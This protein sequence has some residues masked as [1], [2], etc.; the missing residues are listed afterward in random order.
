MSTITSQI[1]LTHEVDPG[2]LKTTETHLRELKEGVL[3][4]EVEVSSPYSI[5]STPRTTDFEEPFEDCTQDCR[6][7]SGIE[8]A[9]TQSALLVTAD[10]SYKIVA[11]FPVPQTLA[12][13]EVMIRNHATGLNHI[14]WKSVDYNFC[15]PELPWITGREMAGVVERVGA[16]VTKYQPGDKVWTSTYYKDRRAGCFQDLVVVPQ[17]TVFP[18]PSSLN[19]NTAACLGVAALTAAMSLWRWLGVPMHP[20]RSTSS[21]PQKPEV[22]LVWGGSTVTGQ[23]AIQVAAQAGL[24]VIAVCSESTASLVASLGAAHVVTYNNKTDLHIIGEILCLADG[25]LTKA[26]DLVGAKTAKLVLQLIAACGEKEVEFA[27]LAFMSSKDPIPSNARVHTVEMKQFVLDST[28]EVYGARLNE[29]VQ[30]GTL[31]L[32]SVKVLEGGLAAVEEGLRINISAMD[33]KP[34]DHR[35]PSTCRLT[36]NHTREDAIAI[37][38]PGAATYRDPFGVPSKTPTVLME[39]AL[40]VLGSYC[41]LDAPGAVPFWRSLARSPRESSEVSSSSNS[42][43]L[44]RTSFEEHAMALDVVSQSANRPYA[45]IWTSHLGHVAEQDEEPGRGKR[46]RVTLACQRCKTRKQKCDGSNPCEKCKANNQECCY[47]IPQKP[48]PFGK[49][50][51]IKALERRVAELET[52]LS[53]QGMTELSSDHWAATAESTT[54]AS[55]ARSNPTPEPEPDEPDEAVLDWRDGV[56]SVV[57]VVR[58]LSLDVN[59]SGY[60][61]AS[62]HVA[63]GRVFAF[64]AK[65]KHREAV[66]TGQPRRQSLAASTAPRHPVNDVHQPIDF[67]DVPAGIADRLFNGYLKHIATRWPVVHSVWVRELH[68]RRHSLTDVFELTML[69][70]LYA[71]AG[72]FIETTGETGEFHVK[73]HYA[74]AAQ[75]LDT[76]HQFNDI[77]TVQVLMLMAVYCLRDSIGPG[78]WTCSR[79]ALLIAIDH[80]LHRQTKALSRLSMESELRKRLFWSCY[81]FDRQIS[82]PMGRPFGISDRDIDVELPLDIDE[83]TTQ[84]QLANLDSILG[85]Q[86]KATSMTSFILIARLRR[87]ESDIQQTVYRVDQSIVIDDAIIDGFLHRLEVWKSTIPQDCRRMRDVGDVPFDGYDYYMVFYHKCLRLLLYPQISKTNVAPRFLKECAKAC[88]GICG[89]Y[90][91]LHQTLAVGYSFMALQTVFMAG[92][93]LV[94]CIWISPAEIFDMITSNGIHD[95]SILLFVIAERVLPAKKYRNAFEVIRQRVIDHISQE[96]AAPR[97]AMAG[98]TEELA[99]S[100]QSFQVNMP[101]EVDNGSFEEFSQII[102]DMTGEEFAGALG[103]AGEEHMGDATVDFGA[104]AMYRMPE[105]FGTGMDYGTNG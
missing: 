45:P 50:Q 71:T 13:H 73:R 55:D 21:Q 97:E 63:L 19:F 74:S 105:G 67:A 85:S 30:D 6:R 12:P 15:L 32:P 37:A 25:R 40:S 87:I 27:P 16:G 101:F 31:R 104:G 54:S 39:Q 98:L 64:L 56:D 93:T 42:V 8:L 76:I 58:S 86:T 51:Y 95:C 7:D 35:L 59:G 46:S 99:P 44:G 65:T 9:Q 34:F 29:M 77:R 79:T 10:R 103:R 89:A 41:T 22:M 102:T 96:P 43:P 24:D 94:Y 18:I 57:S 5:A 88:A 69:H 49:N 48:M 62:S 72:R 26:V 91:R 81:A 38:P 84:E 70:L 3:L 78:A 92:L 33:K 90:K 36:L 52:F 61:G 17:H 68:A 60:M 66:E 83:D 1:T 14:D 2:T 23:F 53:T 82:I 75:S 47:V 100:A 28:S 20:P 80:G 4:D 11:D